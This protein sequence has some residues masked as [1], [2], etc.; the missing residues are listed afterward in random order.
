[1][2]GLTLI[3]RWRYSTNPSAKT[4]TFIEW[5]R[6]NSHFTAANT[7]VKSEETILGGWYTSI[8]RNV[9]TTSQV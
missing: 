4:I 7:E 6:S 2:P 1:M 8:N 9:N 3:D 5:S